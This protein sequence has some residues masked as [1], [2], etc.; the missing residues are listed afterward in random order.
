[1][2]ETESQINKIK[3]RIGFLFEEELLS[4]IIH[5]GKIK[6]V[7]ADD[8]LIDT[9]EDILYIPFILSGALK[10]SRD[11][12]GEELLLY[13][14]E[15]GDTCTMTLQNSVRSSKSEIRATVL[16]DSEILLI[17]VMFMENWMNKYPSWRHYIIDS[18]HSRMMELMETIDA[19]TFK[20]LDERL[21][22]YLKDQA[23]LS[24]SLEI[25]MTHQQIAE[26]LNSSRVVIS[27]LLKRLESKGQIQLFR[28]RIVLDSI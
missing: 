18:Y 16:E 5:N 10:I 3:E 24:G 23:K 20:R 9:G 6:I 21:D 15:S 1:M 7:K 22:T 26:D 2:I 17:P 11:H 28:N 27:R 25:N 8:V 12:N 13:Y 19:I 4:E 14:I